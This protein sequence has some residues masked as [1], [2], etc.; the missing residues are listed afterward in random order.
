MMRSAVFADFSGGAFQRAE[1]GDMTIDPTATTQ[2]AA[3]TPPHHHHHGHGRV[4]QAVDAAAQKLGMDPSE[5]QQDLG[6]GQSLDD[7]AKD[8][9]VSQDDLFSTMTDALTQAGASQDAASQIA[10]RL[11]DRQWGRRDDSAPPARPPRGTYVD[12]DA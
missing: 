8:K 11:A 10:Q 9:G 4:K 2:Q 5:L 3:A 7:I 6:N 1:Y 12:V